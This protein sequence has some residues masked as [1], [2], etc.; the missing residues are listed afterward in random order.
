MTLA[1]TLVLAGFS[2]PAQ[3]QEMLDYWSYDDYADD[4]SM[5]GVDGWYTGYERDEWNGYV[6][7][8]TGNTSSQVNAQA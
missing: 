3:A 4:Q 8:S 2:S 5:V 1:L 7:S 6:S